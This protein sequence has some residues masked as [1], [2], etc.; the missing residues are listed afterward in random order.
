MVKTHTESR[1]AP[2][3]N[4]AQPQQRTESAVRVQ[5]TSCRTKNKASL[6]LRA[7]ARAASSA[8]QLW[9][10]QASD[11]VRWVVA[12]AVTLWEQSTTNHLIPQIIMAEVRPCS[13]VTRHRNLSGR[14]LKVC[15]P[16]S[17]AADTWCMVAPVRPHTPDQARWRHPIEQL[18]KHAYTCNSYSKL[19]SGV[20]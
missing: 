15:T 9:P 13:V 1:E 10:V 8:A 16:T 18:K 19:I 11:Q 5:W 4:Q 6:L 2:A 12:P 3:K 14:T 17:P 7:R 20:K